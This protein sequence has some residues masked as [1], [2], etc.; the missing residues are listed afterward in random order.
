MV[1]QAHHEGLGAL[2]LLTPSPLGGEGWG[3]GAFARE[4]WAKTPHPA[5]RATFSPEGRRKGEDQIICI[6]LM[7]CVLSLLLPPPCGEGLRV[8]VGP[9]GQT[10]KLQS[11]RKH[12]A[13]GSTPPDPALPGHPPHQ[14]EGKRN[15]Q[16]RAA[17]CQTG[18]RTNQP[19]CA[20]F[21]C[22]TGCR[23]CPVRPGPHL[24]SVCNRHRAGPQRPGP[25]ALFP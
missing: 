12:G 10:R 3:E 1:R 23:H 22:L 14:G 17:N 7:D 13:C 24:Q 18:R 5:L 9:K 6:P 11:L 15:S 2:R 21:P 19:G 25:D 20:V 16:T 4:L 8:G